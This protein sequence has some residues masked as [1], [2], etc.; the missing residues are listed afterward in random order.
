MI[1]GP[2]S[3]LLTVTRGSDPTDYNMFQVGTSLVTDVTVSGMTI[4]GADDGVVGTGSAFQVFDDEVRNVSFNDVVFSHQ[5]AGFGAGLQVQ[6]ITR[7][8]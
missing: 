5:N 1:V 2:G 8:C 4:T 7:H 6:A 3:E